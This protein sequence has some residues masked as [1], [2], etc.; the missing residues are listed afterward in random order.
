[1]P[2]FWIGLKAYDLIAGSSAL[3]WSRFHDAL[4][5][6]TL[7]PTLAPQ[8][9]DGET[10]KGSVRPQTELSGAPSHTPSDRVL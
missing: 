2:Y 9:T 7:L 6:R 4:A 1:M 10:L 5:S 3:A 8:H